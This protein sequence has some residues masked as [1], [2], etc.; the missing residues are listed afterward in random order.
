[1]NPFWGYAL[2]EKYGQGYYSFSFEFNQGAFQTRL[3][4]ADKFLGDLKEVTLPASA[5]G[6][7]AWYF[8]QLNKE[9]LILNLR[10]PVD[11]QVV[12]QW[13]NTPQTVYL[14]GWA[15]NEKLEYTVDVNMVKTYDGI[16]F[17]D[18][19]TASRPN[20]N[21]LKMVANRDGL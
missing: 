5:A 3:I 21:A 12:E 20:A 10:A 1:M 9:V 18:T 17:I 8:A 19:T 2:R 7:L 16:I 11:N 13:L 15:F 14:A 4:Q 6:T